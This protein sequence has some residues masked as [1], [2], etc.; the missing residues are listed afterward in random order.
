M[1]RIA[2]QPRPARRGTLTGAFVAIWLAVTL[3]AA[4]GLLM[5]A[6]LS[7]PGAGRVDGADAGVRVDPTVP[8][9]HVAAAEAVDD[10]PAPP[11]ARDA[12]ERVAAV[13]GVARA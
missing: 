2:R 8:I 9:G 7:S 3:A 5:A 11:L 4:T 12:V 10:T 13:P 1:L 6:A